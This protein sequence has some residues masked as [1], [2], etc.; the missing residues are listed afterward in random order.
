MSDKPMNLRVLL[1]VVTGITFLFAVSTQD[2]RAAPA[3]LPGPG[4]KPHALGTAEL[5]HAVLASSVEAAAARK[6]VQDFLARSEVRE[7]ITRMGFEPSVVAS[8]TALLSDSELLR[9]NAQVM[10]TDQQI[11]TA[12]LPGW[13][14]TFIVISTVLV[15][16]V[17]LMD[18]YID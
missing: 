13:A 18:H 11:R 4:E 16:L 5:H 15:I 10:A 7:Q 17:I 12:G 6:S 2:L 1:T 8:H 9:L 3:G 14:I